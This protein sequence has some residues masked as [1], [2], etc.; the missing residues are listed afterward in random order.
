MSAGDNYILT[1]LR[2]QHFGFIPNRRNWAQK[3]HHLWLAQIMRR[4]IG[5]H[6][7]RAFINDVHG[8]L[9]TTGAQAHRPIEDGGKI[10]FTAAVDHRT[11]SVIHRTEKHSRE[12]YRDVVFRV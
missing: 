5:E 4:T 6:L 10:L 9:M 11:R 2:G 3:L 7:Q 1:H 8:Q 12:W